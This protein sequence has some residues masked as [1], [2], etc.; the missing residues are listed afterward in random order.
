MLPGL[1]GS[2][3]NK[4]LVD[5]LKDGEWDPGV[6]QGIAF[7]WDGFISDGQHRLA[8]IALTKIAADIII[9]RNA[10]WSAFDV[11]DMQRVRRPGQM[12]GDMPHSGL[13]IR[14]A[15]YLYPVLLGT[16][17]TD[18]YSRET[19]NPDLVEMVRAWPLF[20]GPWLAEV[21]AVHQEY[22]VPTS[23]LGAVVV[24]AL[25][26]GANEDDVQ[27]FLNGMRRR[28]KEAF[29]SIGTDGED[30]RYLLR[31]QFSRGSQGRIPEAESFGNA[32]IL[33]QAMTVWLERYSDKPI[34]IKKFQRAVYKKQNLPPFWR[35]GEISKYHN[36]LF[37]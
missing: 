21:Q 22:H 7:T 14:I 28:H 20:H 18:Y 15:K 4:G 10:S 36:S 13:A 19:S 26:A 30:P 24:G 32:G 8:A 9:T 11:T 33:R 23:P 5:V 12:L 35:S 25:A 3:Y 34:K 2:K 27:Q 31:M 16:Q 37:G 29:P 1:Y 6:S 17:E